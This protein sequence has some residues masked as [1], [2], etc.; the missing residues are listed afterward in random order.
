[1]SIVSGKIKLTVNNKVL[2]N[3]ELISGLVFQHSFILDGCNC[4][5]LQQGDNIEFRINNKAFLHLLNQEK[6]KKEFKH[7]ED[8]K[9]RDFVYDPSNLDE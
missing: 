3:S 1:M 6:T 7:C 5:V 8:E 9:L 4:I 2:Q